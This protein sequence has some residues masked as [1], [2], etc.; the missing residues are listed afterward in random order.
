MVNERMAWIKLRL[1]EEE[2]S[3]EKRF[4]GDGGRAVGDWSG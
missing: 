3:R 4:K 1:K 2:L